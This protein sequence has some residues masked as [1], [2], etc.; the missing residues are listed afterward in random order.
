MPA[1]KRSILKQLQQDKTGRRALPACAMLPN[2]IEL[3]L[4]VAQL[5]PNKSPSKP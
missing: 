2:P 5:N 4:L 1:V 3:P